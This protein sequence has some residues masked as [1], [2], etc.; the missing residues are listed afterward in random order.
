MGGSSGMDKRLMQQIQP[1]ACLFFK[2]CK[3][4]YDLHYPVL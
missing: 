2:G 4:V 1:S 3:F